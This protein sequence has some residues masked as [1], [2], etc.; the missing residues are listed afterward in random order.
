MENFIFCAFMVLN[1]PPEHD[2]LYLL[3]IKSFSIHAE[4]MILI[5]LQSNFIE[6]TL[7]HGCC[8]VNLLHIF[9]EHLWTAASVNTFFSLLN[10]FLDM[11]SHTYCA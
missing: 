11:H 6:I 2:A 8:P 7:Q 5:K 1:E 9:K 10:K 3:V 4:S